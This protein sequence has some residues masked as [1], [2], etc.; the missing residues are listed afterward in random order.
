MHGKLNL[1]RTPTFT[2]YQF[3]TSRFIPLFNSDL[4]HTILFP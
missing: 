1:Y 3:T 2:N 4:K